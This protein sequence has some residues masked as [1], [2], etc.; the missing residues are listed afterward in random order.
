[1][2]GL[3]QE[4]AS[5]VTKAAL[6]VGVST[7]LTIGGHVDD[8]IKLATLLYIVLQVVALVVT[9]VILWRKGEAE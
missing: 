1:M 7:W 2:N 8:W 4:V 3:S 5:S 6:P 9:K